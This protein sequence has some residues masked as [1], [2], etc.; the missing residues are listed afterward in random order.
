ME[1]DRRYRPSALLCHAGKDCN[2][3]HINVDSAKYHTVIPFNA[4]EEAVCSCKVD[5]PFIPPDKG[6]R[7]DSIGVTW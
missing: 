6:Y 5:P 2:I 3:D 4:M 7:S 1:N